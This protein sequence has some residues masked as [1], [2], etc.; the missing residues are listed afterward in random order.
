MLVK[1]YNNR[2]KSQFGQKKSHTDQEA[3]NYI[4][5][6]EGISPKGITSNL[7][8]K[9]GILQEENL[10]M[11]QGSEIAVVVD[12]DTIGKIGPQLTQAQRVTE[13]IHLQRLVIKP[14]A[15][16]N[17]QAQKKKKINGK[18]KARTPGISTTNPKGP[19]IAMKTAKGKEKN[20]ELEGM[21]MVVTEYMRRMEQD[22][23][24]AFKISKGNRTNLDGHMIRENLLFNPDKQQL[25]PN[26]SV[27]T[28]EHRGNQVKLPDV[29]MSDAG[30]GRLDASSSQDHGVRRGVGSKAFPSL[31]RDL[32]HEYG[33]NMFFLLETHVSGVRGNQIR[34]KIG[35]DTSFVVDAVGHAGG[36]RCLWDSSVW[37]VDVLEHDKQFVH[38]NVERNC[39]WRIGDGSQI[40]FWDHNWVPGVG[41]LS[42]SATQVSNNINFSEMLMDFL[43]I[44][45]QWDT[46][47]E[48]IIKKIVAIF[49]RPLGRTQTI[50]PGGLPR[51]EHSVRSQP[52]N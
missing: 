12:Q 29:T 6:D 38:L 26:T 9:F 52:T 27:G 30:G 32:R 21:E 13:E 15:G 18:N 47:P 7:G 2:K 41:R 51:T 8:S 50:L 33:A 19:E 34:D 49:P 44:S 43:D 22:R 31:I 25:P 1:K 39:I 3:T 46:L 35:F 24:E 11:V 4:S 28:T 17:P 42:E 16:K 23:W 40:Y 37:S 45:G 10:E 36:I 14:G 48:E 5:T 20:A